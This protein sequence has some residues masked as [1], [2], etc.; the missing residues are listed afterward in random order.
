M[1]FEVVIEMEFQ[2]AESHLVKKRLSKILRAALHSR[3]FRN[4]SE[5]K[6]RFHFYY[7]SFYSELHGTLH[8]DTNGRA[9]EANNTPESSGYNVIRLYERGTVYTWS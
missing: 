8:R 3:V 5:L 7:N 2:P 9:W 6:F 4:Q 1:P